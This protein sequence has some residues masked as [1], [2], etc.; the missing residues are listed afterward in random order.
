MASFDK[1]FS[2]AGTILLLTALAAMAAGPASAAD[3]SVTAAPGR[4]TLVQY[5]VTWTD[6]CGQGYVPKGGLSAGP[7]HGK[8][9]FRRGSFAI[10]KTASRGS[11]RDCSGR[12]ISG[13]GVYYTADGGYRGQDSFRMWIDNGATATTRYAVAVSVK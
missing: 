3:I 2:S 4:E 10:P 9:A 1:P 11:V 6:D 8:V 5:Y 7:A 13:L 12:K